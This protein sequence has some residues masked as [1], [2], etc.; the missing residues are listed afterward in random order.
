M[1]SEIKKLPKSQV[2]ILIEV[3]PEE[4]HPYLIK[5]AQKIAATAK[6][7]GF[8]PG[9]AP[10]EVIKQKFGEMAILQEALDDIVAKTYTEAV[11]EG[12]IITI[13]QPQIEIQKM[14]PGEIFAYKATASILPKV[15]VGDYKDLK[16]EKKKIEVKK[17]EVSKVIDDLRKMRASEVLVERE[18][19]TGDKAEID[20]DIFL[21]NVLIENGQYKKFP[22]I[23]GEGRF[24]P[25]FEEQLIGLKAGDKKDFK[26]KFPDEYFQKNLAGKEA[27][28]KTSCLGIYEI[29]L[30]ENNDEFAN[31]ISGG[32]FKTVKE[33]EE[34]IEHNLKHEK[35]H[36]ED[37][38]L[39]NE[40]LEKLVAISE[41]EEIPEV[42]IESERHRMMH[43]LK[44]NI[45]KQGFDFNNY[46][47]SIKKTA[48][49]LE[50]ELTPQAEMR[51]KTSIL[52]REIY[53]KQKIEVREDEVLLEIEE[54]AK[55]YPNNPEIR[56]QLE[57]ETYKEYLRNKIGNRKVMEHLKQTIIK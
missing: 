24:I 26:L 23:L 28:F 39:E 40:M 42:L 27:E 5:A 10:F 17:E 18:A 9:K 2:E 20:F 36:E 11:E 34:N 47:A 37:H 52:A 19:K 46:L 41:F 6:I 4:I 8:R 51:A 50:K 3:T 21:D 16:V 49:E 22:A 53:Q 43:E 15:T 7:E 44:D 45:A 54:L 35:E 1:K 33:L 57:A 32:Q 25:G 30:P 38:R 31:A 55:G 13:D 48:E 12:K 29:V 14:A 56:K